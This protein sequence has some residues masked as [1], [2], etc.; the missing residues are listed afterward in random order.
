LGRRLASPE[1]EGASHQLSFPHTMICVHESEEH[2]R[3]KRD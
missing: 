3:T 2:P 1:T